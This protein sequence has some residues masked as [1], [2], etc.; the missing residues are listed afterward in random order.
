MPL[1]T[2]PDQP[3]PTMQDHLQMA[4]RADD[5]GF[6]ALWMRDVPFYDPS[7]GDV[8]QVFEP[9]VYI[10]VL[11]TVTKSI[12]LGT[13]GIVLPLREPKMLAKQVTSLDHLSSG[14]MMLGL[15]SGDRPPEYPLFDIDFASRGD[16]FRDAFDVYRS[17]TERDFPSFQSRHFGQADGKLDLIPKPPFGRTPSIAIGRGQQSLDWIAANMDDLIAPSPAVELLSAFASQWHGLVREV[18]GEAAFKPI[19]LAGY[20]D[21]VEDRDHPFQQ[22]RAG[23][24]TGSKALATFLEKARAAGV[25]HA[26]LNPKVSRRPY[27]DLMADL[28][29]DVPPLFPSLTSADQAHAG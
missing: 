20:L 4:R 11:A 8:G 28:A 29:A 18:E 26:T 14:R 15:S 13:A 23:I 5:A 3:A 19:G 22:M 21:L 27:A 24:R 9:L 6:T 7:Y 17:V 12:A 25:N 16:R 1:E 2:Y 10:A